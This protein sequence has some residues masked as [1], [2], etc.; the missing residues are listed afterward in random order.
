VGGLAEQITVYEVTRS[1]RSLLRLDILTVSICCY[2]AWFYVLDSPGLL[3]CILY[4]V[5]TLFKDLTMFF[6][7]VRGFT[8]TTRILR[9]TSFDILIAVVA[10]FIY[11]FNVKGKAHVRDMIVTYVPVVGAVLVTRLLVVI[12]ANRTLKSV[13]ENRQ[14]RE[15]LLTIN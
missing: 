12:L 7:I 2:T 1:F 8:R 15:R 3:A 13:A 9:L 5:W 11:D 6:F 4:F 10:T 14:R